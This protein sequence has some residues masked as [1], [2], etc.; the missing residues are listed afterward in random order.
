MCARKDISY[1]KNNACEKRNLVV[2]TELPLIRLVDDD[3][4]FRVSQTM[5]LKARGWQVEEFESGEAFLESA[6]LRR[7]G[8]II[9]DVR[10]SGMSGMQ[11][12]RELLNRGCRLAVIFLTGHGDIPMAVRAM[13]RGAVSFLEKPVKPFELLEAVQKAVES[14]LEAAQKDEQASKNRAIFDEL[15]AREKE[16]VMRAALDTP[17]KVIARELGIAEPTVKMHRGHAFAKLG[18]KSPL[19]AYRVLLRLGVM[20]DD[21]ADSVQSET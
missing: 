17:N 15:T 13:Q 21:Q 12:H 3:E 16:I 2:K 14:S 19:E 1:G 6:D 18:V 7:P 9:L 20:K 5:L 11:V 8:C 10:M 4:L